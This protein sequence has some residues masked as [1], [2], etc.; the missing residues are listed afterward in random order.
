MTNK[1][2]LIDETTHTVTFTRGELQDIMMALIHTKLA[3]EGQASRTGKDAVPV[4]QQIADTEAIIK[5][6]V[7]ELAR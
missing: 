7:A 4:D 5:K 3:C 6:V 1:Y 2:S